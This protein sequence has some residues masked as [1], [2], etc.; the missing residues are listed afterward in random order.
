MFHAVKRTLA[1]TLVFAGLVLNSPAQA[2]QPRY[3]YLHP[4]VPV[5]LQKMFTQS[6]VQHPIWQLE[7][8]E[9]ERQVLRLQSLELK[10]EAP[11]Y[12]SRTRLDERAIELVAK[13]QLEIWKGPEL[14]WER[15]VSLRRPLRVMGPELRG[16]GMAVISP[17]AELP[18]GAL[19]QADSAVVTQLQQQLLA[20]AAHQLLTDYRQHHLRE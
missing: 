18:A 5:S 11:F 12:W 16:T 1:G 15:S 13:L 10:T 14:R 8:E 9:D 6:M 17:L 4:S 2:A 20:V 7:L 19:T 3:A